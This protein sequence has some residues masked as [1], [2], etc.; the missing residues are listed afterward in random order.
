[1]RLSY[2]RGSAGY[3]LVADG[4]RLQT[5]D[6][7]LALRDTIEAE[8]GDLPFVLMVNKSDLT[9]DW[10]IDDARLDELAG[11]GWDLLKSSAKEGIGVEE[12]FLRLT[13]KMLS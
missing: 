11:Q 2:L 6:T 9:D 5:L 8:M 1:M 13:E 3:L 4:T 12:A 10:E 7:A